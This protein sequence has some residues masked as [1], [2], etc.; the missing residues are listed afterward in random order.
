MRFAFSLLAATSLLIAASAAEDVCKGCGCKGGPGYRG[1]N[2]QCVGWAQ[3]NK[4]CGT[5]PST[6]C[7]A[8]GPALL[9][10]GAAAVAKTLRPGDSSNAPVPKD[11]AS[12]PDVPAES[13]EQK[14]KTSG[15]ACLAVP[16]LQAVKTC[17]TRTPSVDCEAEKKTLIETGACVAIGR[18]EPLTI[19]AGSRSFDWLRVRVKGRSEDMWVERSMILAR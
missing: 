19:K 2:G 7:G 18:D 17:S 1:P 8:E 4:V 15:V 14:T 3:L 5:P 10:L 11:N 9:A 12:D 16:T 6:R 13:N